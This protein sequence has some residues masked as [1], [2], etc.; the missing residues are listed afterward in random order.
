MQTSFWRSVVKKVG[1][2][3][4]VVWLAITLAFFALRVIPG[5]AITSQYYQAGFS[6][7]AIAQRIA[8]LGLDRPIHIQYVYYLSSLLQGNL[9]VSLYTGLPVTYEI[10]QRL[11]VTLRLTGLSMSFAVIMGVLLGI[12]PGLR[13][14]YISRIA[15]LITYFSFGIPV[16]WT[17]TLA[18]FLVTL[19]FSE[20]AESLIIPALVLGFHTA[21]AIARVL[22]SQLEAVYVNTTW[23]VVARSKG[24]GEFRLFWTHVIPHT[25]PQLITIIALQT[26]IL[27]SGTVIT[28]TIFQQT[29]IGLLLLDRTIERDYPVVQGIVIFMS[30]TYA[31]LNMGAD[32]MSAFFDPRV[33]IQ[34]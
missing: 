10:G 20:S 6:D 26:G 23:I 25:I 22:Q 13:L 34:S 16:Y 12:L 9:G 1:E 7:E 32:I 8:E 28:E 15:S 4:I 11:P 30:V 29:G 24:L 27:L 17:A 21:G 5:D 19:Q 18:Y 2:V 14:K 31:V 3:I 33:R